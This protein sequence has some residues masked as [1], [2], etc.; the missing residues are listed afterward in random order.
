MVSEMGFKTV[1]RELVGGF[2]HESISGDFGEDGCG[3][4]G[5]IF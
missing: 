4:N 3:G 5:G 1:A 2:D